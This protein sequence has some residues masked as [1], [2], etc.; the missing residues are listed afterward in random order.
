[1]SSSQPSSSATTT[2]ASGVLL[3]D[4]VDDYLA[5]SQACINPLFQAPKTTKSSNINGNDNH[6]TS[7]AV[8]IPRRKRR[9]IRIIGGN[10]RN[11][12][13]NKGSM[14]VPQLNITEMATTTTTKKKDNLIQ[15]SMADCLACSGCV[16]TAETVLLEQEHSLE[17]LRKKCNITTNDYSSSSNSY[18]SNH[19]FIRALT[20][21]PSSWADLFRQLGVAMPSANDQD[22]TEDEKHVGVTVVES[23]QRQIVTLMH[24]IIRVTLV[25]NGTLPLQWSLEES[26]KEFCE[27]YR[28]TKQR[29]EQHQGNRNTIMEIPPPSIPVDAT[30]TRYYPPDCQDVNGVEYQNVDKPFV[31]NTQLPL[32]SGACPAV[33]CLI[34]KSKHALVTQLATS[35]S[36]TALTGAMLHQMATVATTTSSSSSSAAAAVAAATTTMEN[37]LAHHDDSYQYEYDHWAIMPCHDKKLEASRKDFVQPRQTTPTTYNA[38]STK[39]EIELVI[40]TKEWYQLIRDYVGTQLSQQEDEQ[41]EVTNATSRDVLAYIQRLPMAKIVYDQL[42]LPQT[43]RPNEIASLPIFAT[44]S[45]AVSN[46]LPAPWSPVPTIGPLSVGTTVPPIVPLASGGHADFIFRSA[47]RELFQCELDGNLDIWY[48]VVASTTV[49]GLNNASGVSNNNNHTNGVTSARVANRLRKTADYYQAIL[50]RHLQQHADPS[51]SYYYTTNESDSSNPEP[52]LKF[53][54]ANGLQTLNRVFASLTAAKGGAD[55]SNVKTTMMFDYVEAMACPSGCINGGGQLRLGSVVDKDIPQSS[56]LSS[57]SSTTR[58]T[59]TQ[60]RQRVSS[61]QDWLEVTTMST[62]RNQP[63]HGGARSSLV[64]EP[65][66]PATTTTT[67]PTMVLHQHQKRTR[68]HV[69][70]LMKHTMGAAAGV[71]VQDIQW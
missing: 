61:T 46:I 36:P 38:S 31:E 55:A 16:T 59:P 67:M 15:A 30:R 50:Y 39:K 17:S 56:S 70:P 64:E 69:V 62:R 24:Q 42:P 27:V 66:P 60:T 13:N 34:E 20:I 51:P 9:P 2:E 23:L 4:N 35:K 71:A 32:I 48:P 33:V 5:P 40:T 65:P 8:V 25:I 21:S 10:D 12:D 44:T 6:N 18:N 26:A 54:I 11:N 1:M 41:A 63:I 49:Y 37:G 28:Q 22:H 53:A 14:S 45:P 52:V 3:L 58:E 47:A 57:P 29:E 7:T 43:L 68:Y 19:R